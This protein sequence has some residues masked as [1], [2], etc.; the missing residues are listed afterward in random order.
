MSYK[1]QRTVYNMQFEDYPGLEVSAQSAS[2]GRLFKFQGMSQ[3]PLEKMSEEFQKDIFGFF[4]SRIITWNVSHPDLDSNELEE[5]GGK[6]VCSVCGMLPDAPLPT[7]QEAMFC[8]PL[9]FIMNII[10]GWM[11]TL[12]K[13]SDPKG[14]SLN[15]GGSTTPAQQAMEVMQRLAEM[16][17]PR[18]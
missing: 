8:L 14:G 16:Q 17:S 3:M 10:K 5:N 18:T 7:T 9:E 4:A 13:V 15:N 12:M 6:G 1:P 2:L 11:E